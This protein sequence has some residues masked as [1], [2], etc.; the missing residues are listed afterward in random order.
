MYFTI[1][2]QTNIT[3]GVAPIILVLQMPRNLDGYSSHYLTTILSFFNLY[4]RLGKKAVPRFSE[5]FHCSCLL[6]MSKLSRSIHATRGPP[7][8]R[9]LQLHFISPGNATHSSPRPDLFVVE[10]S[11][12]FSA[13]L[14]L[15]PHEVKVRPRELVEL[16]LQPPDLRVLHLGHRL[17]EKKCLLTQI[18]AP[19]YLDI[20]LPN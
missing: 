12:A 9:A 4:K 17:L 13:L 10:V 18:I 16:V 15:L 5:F 6:L 2:N 3:T 19:K 8:N 14:E 1:D 20:V 11:G 7:F